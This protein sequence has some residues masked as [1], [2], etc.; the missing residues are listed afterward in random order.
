MQIK[1]LF[2]SKVSYFNTSNQQRIYFSV[3]LIPMPDSM[4]NSL[5]L[6]NTKPKWKSW[7]LAQFCQLIEYAWLTNSSIFFISIKYFGFLISLI[8]KKIVYIIFVNLTHQKMRK[9]WKAWYQDT[10]STFVQSCF[11]RSKIFVNAKT[12]TLCQVCI[13]SGKTCINLFFINT[14]VKL[15][16]Q[17][18]FEKGLKET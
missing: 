17:E 6:F 8:S 1:C 10:F 4:Q 12:L 7:N 15:V 16:Q 14:L 18:T 5:F 3:D 13:Y 11:S 2:M 9:N